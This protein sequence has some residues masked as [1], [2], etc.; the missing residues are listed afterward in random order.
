VS[1]HIRRRYVNRLRLSSR[2]LPI[3]DL[4]FWLPTEA[5]V[6]V[7]EFR[8]LLLRPMD[9]VHVDAIQNTVRI[10]NCLVNDRDRGR[11]GYA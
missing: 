2:I 1:L 9:E 6:L 11:I 8:L 10:E 3:R 7:I 4:R 5:S